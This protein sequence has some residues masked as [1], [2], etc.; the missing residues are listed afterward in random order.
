M[1]LYFNK[2]LKFN[3]KVVKVKKYEFSISE[4]K[5]YKNTCIVTLNAPIMAYKVLPNKNGYIY[6]N[7][8]SKVLTE[9]EKIS[10]TIAKGIHVNS[11]NYFA[12]ESICEYL[13]FHSYLYNNFDITC[14]SFRTTVKVSKNDFVA[15]G[16]FHEHEVYTK[17]KLDLPKLK[18]MFV[19]EYLKLTGIK[20]K[21]EF[22]LKD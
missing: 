20:C 11:K 10:S 7:R 9:N 14:G 1:C 8:K 17:I 22:K 4:K 12:S 18:K 21:F 15:S 2:N 16:K 3:S 13:K 19:K 6:S 5:G